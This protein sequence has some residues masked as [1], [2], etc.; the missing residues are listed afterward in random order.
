MSDAFTKKE[1]PLAE[2]S[3]MSFNQVKP[4]FN[5]CNQCHDSSRIPKFTSL[6]FENQF[7]NH[8]QWIEKIKDR[9]T[10]D[11]GDP[12]KMPQNYVQWSSEDLN[13]IKM[14]LEQGAPDESGKPTVNW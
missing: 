10:R 3:Q 12:L 5:I 6:P 13:K 7:G 4:L 2:N 1:K 14:W 11:D 8:K 9:V